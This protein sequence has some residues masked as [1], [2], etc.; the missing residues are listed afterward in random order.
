MDKATGE[1]PVVMVDFVTLTPQSQFRSGMSTGLRVYH[2]DGPTSNAC[3][4]NNGGCQHLCLPNGINSKVCA[5]SMGFQLNDDGITCSSET[6]FDS[7]CFPLYDL[8]FS[9]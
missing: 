8:Y 7:F 1:N 5:C 3:S 6:L 2:R 9:S 4:D